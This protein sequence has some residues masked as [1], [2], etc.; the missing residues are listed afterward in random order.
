MI[1][2]D[3]VLLGMAKSG[4]TS[5]FEMLSNHHQI[6]AS[7][8]KEPISE[9]RT[10]Q[11]NFYFEKYFKCIDGKTK[12]LLDGTPGPYDNVEKRKVLES[13]SKQNWVRNLKVIYTLRNPIERLVSQMLTLERAIHKY[14]DGLSWFRNWF[15]DDHSVKHETLE[16]ICTT[17]I[18]S[19]CIDK[20]KEFTKE[21]CIV[22]LNTLDIDFLL[23]FLDIEKIKLNLRHLNKTEETFL[24][25]KKMMKGI[26][27]FIYKNERVLK[28]VFIS[29]MKK[30]ENDFNIDLSDIIES[31]GE[32]L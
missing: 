20:A 31:I 24:I 12:I 26:N 18:D 16:M 28:D 6:C 23:N 14:P 19:W 27:E 15:N 11:P 13:I 7:K 30:I 3:L 22:K 21:I 5:T 2:Y 29:D 8:R 10:I 32:Y 1:K 4:T 25:P 9:L 17:F